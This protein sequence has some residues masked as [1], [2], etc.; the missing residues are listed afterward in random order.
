MGE[1]SLAVAE[2]GTQSLSKAEQRKLDSDHLRD[3]LLSELS[4]DDVRFTEDAVQLLKFH[5]SYQQHHRELRKTDKV[6]SWQMML[7]L[8]SPGGRIPA[9]LF[10][11]LDDLSNRLGDGTL[12]ATT[13]QA[14]QM[15]GIA[16]ADLKEVIGTIVRNMGST[17]A[18]CG[19]INRNVMAPPAPFEKG[20]Y[21]VARRLADEIA[22]LL[23]PEAAEGAYLDLWVDGDLSYRFKPSRAV[24]KARKRQSEGGVFSGS[25]EEPLYGDTYLPRKFK[26][27][28]TVPGDNS[29]DLLTQDIGLVAFTDPSGDLRGC[30]V[31]VG[32]GMGRTHNKEETFARTADCLG[33]I[34]GSQILDLVQA[35]VALQRDHG[36]RVVR[37][38][39]RM[40]YLLHDR[41]IAWF[42]EEIGRY[43]DGPIAP[44]Q[45]ETTPE[46][47]DYLG[48]HPQGDGLWF[49]GL[50]L[51]CGRLDGER[52]RGL[53]ALVERYQPEIR[54]TANQDLLL[55]NIGK[56]QRQEISEALAELG[57][58][59]PTETSLLGRHAIA[60]PAL[61]TCGLAITESERILPQVLERLET[62]LDEEGI[63]QPIL[64]RMTG[65][66]NGCARPYMAELAL[67]GS[68]VDQYQLW[69]G[70]SAGLTRLAR[71]V[72]QRMPLA[73]LETTLRPLLK[74]WL[75]R[76]PQASFGD[77]CH[78][79]GE[80]L[81][82]LLQA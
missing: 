11:A 66:P 75:S 43:F 12:R 46:L 72:L 28:V 59:E 61:P 70:G 35:V 39:A 22:D 44:A 18:A 51:L 5:G 3:P 42:R 79:L 16:K 62:L 49:V 82:A 53:R 64:V 31:Y 57:W 1:G 52:K 17:L 80:E 6:R 20:G 29:V 74:L 68:G 69:L 32:G 2:T 63:E 21:P 25:T 50:P 4:N 10:L 30:N 27:A 78:G 73:D 67:V 15:H 26:V 8:R 34:K 33:Y 56:T 81:D 36:D 40:K 60:C 38:H 24:Q 76:S 48:W 77:F 71:P 54:L 65:C 19:D 47:L 41:G 45:K 23:S 55:C 14:F 13:R 58:S 9:R 37:R 7:R